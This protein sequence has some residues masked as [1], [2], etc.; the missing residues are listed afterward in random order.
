ME[1]IF[2]NILEINPK[3]IF[4]HM[5]KDFYNKYLIN[6]LL[7]INKEYIKIRR[8]L[9]NLIHKISKKNGI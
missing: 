6:S 7:Y 4:G 8:V 1:E 5:K 3:E 2:L 9:I